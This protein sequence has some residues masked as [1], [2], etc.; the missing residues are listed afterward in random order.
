M[1]ELRITTAVIGQEVHVVI[2]L[3]ALLRVELQ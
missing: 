2:P 3:A 1:S